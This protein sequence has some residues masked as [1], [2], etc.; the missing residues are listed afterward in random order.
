VKLVTIGLVLF[1]VPLVLRAEVLATCGASDGYAYFPPGPLVPKD[2]SGWTPDGISK[3]SFQLIRS[4]DDYDI[5]FTDTTGGTLSAKADGGLI[6]TTASEHGNLLVIVLYP[7]KTLETYVFW[8]S[9]KAEKTV[10]Y[11]QAK[12]GATIPKHS[13]MRASCKW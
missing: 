9:V 10:T 2:E 4:G 13:L 5:I 8:F 1:L 6:T 12:Y 7:S 11:S 3:G